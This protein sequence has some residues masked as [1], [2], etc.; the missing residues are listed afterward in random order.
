MLHLTEEEVAICAEALNNN[1]YHKVPQHIQEHLSNCDQCA[2][3]VLLVADIAEDV[4]FH[5][6]FN[7]Q[8]KYR[9][10]RRLVILGTSVAAALVLVFLLVNTDRKDGGDLI[11]QN[12]Q[13]TQSASEDAAAEDETKDEEK[14]DALKDP[15]GSVASPGSGKPADEQSSDAPE[16]SEFLAEWEPDENLEKL[17]ARSHDSLRNAGEIDVDQS[18][19][20]YSSRPNVQLSWSNPQNQKVFIEVFDNS[21]EKLLEDE[22]SGNSYTLEDMEEGLYYWKLISADFDLLFCGRIIIE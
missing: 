7:Q 22:T 13:P 17:V 8:K 5:Q 4:D 9:K 10:V 6:K 15:P 14:G 19:T 12:Q 3:E 2:D 18:H 11:S 20:I 16:L 21:G 1:E